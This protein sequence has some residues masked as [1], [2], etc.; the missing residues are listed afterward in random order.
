[1]GSLLSKNK[2]LPLLP[3]DIINE[4]ILTRLPVESLVRFRCVCKSWKILLSS[5]PGFAK[6]QLARSRMDSNN[7]T[8]IVM[9]GSSCIFKYKLHLLN[10]S[11]LKVGDSVNGL[12][13]VYH[14]LPD[15]IPLIGIW[16]P[17]TCQY[18]QIF[19]PFNASHIPGN[20]YISIGFGFDPVTDDYKLIRI[21]MS[22]DSPFPLV[23]DVYSC[24]ADSWGNNTVK[25]SFLLHGLLFT[26]PTIVR[27]RP[28]WY[29]YG[30]ES[31]EHYFVMYFDLQHEVFKLLPG[32]KYVMATTACRVMVNL[33]DSLAMMF[34]Y[35]PATTPRSVDV[36]IFNE[37][38]A[39]WNEKA[40]SSAEAVGLKEYDN[41][42]PCIFPAA[43]L[44]AL[45]EAYCL[46]DPEVGYCQGMSDLLSPIITV[47][48]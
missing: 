21:T 10:S 42:E 27:G 22:Y 34:D 14:H 31:P 18:K 9:Y 4:E 3:E 11:Y 48:T 44:V 36:Y 29:N 8:L 46:Y 43:R 23:A 45:L 15:S 5:D 40:Q 13:C 38:S 32:I 39:E 33:R 17:A 16:N 25:S 28:Y 12:V 30:V 47:I 7:T 2:S 24:N 35:A 1:M 37:R 26:W 41:H 20:A 19:T 6:S